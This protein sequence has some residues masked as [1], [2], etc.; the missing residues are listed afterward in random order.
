M[1]VQ[2]Q[3]K[4]LTTV[5]RMKRPQEHHTAQQQITSI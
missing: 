4:S 1:T 2:A 5:E 3:M